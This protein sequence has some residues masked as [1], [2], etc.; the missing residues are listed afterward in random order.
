MH[1]NPNV[2]LELARLRTEEHERNSRH[3]MP[4]SVDRPGVRRRL[5]G[6]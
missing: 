6:R 4:R 1:T 3:R 5:L 2:A